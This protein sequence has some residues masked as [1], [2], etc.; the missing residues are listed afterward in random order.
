MPRPQYAGFSLGDAARIANTV[1]AHEGGAFEPPPNPGEPLPD[2]NFARFPYINNC[3]ETLPAHGI[4]RIS[5]TDTVDGRKI[6]VG[7]KVDDTYRWLYAVNGFSDVGNSK[8]G[9]ATWLWH[10]GDVL[11][12][13]GATPAIGERWGPKSGSFLVWQHRPGFWIIG[14]TSGSGSTARVE[15]VQIPPGEVRVQNDSGGAIDAD[16]TGTV[17]LFGGAAGTT[18]LGLEIAVTNG[19][20]V[21]WPSTKYGWVTADAGGLNFVSPY[22]T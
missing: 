4:F 15:A 13:T 7:A 1:R 11:Y 17:N 18:D 10:G 19:S 12:D 6:R 21:S 9:W 3:G 22:Q 14:G 2:R 20:S 16:G 8:R 5:T